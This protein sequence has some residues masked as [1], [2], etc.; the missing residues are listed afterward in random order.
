LS[1]AQYRTLSFLLGLTILGSVFFLPFTYRGTRPLTLY[2]VTRTIQEFLREIPPQYLVLNYVFLVVLVLLLFAGLT[3]VFPMVSGLTSVF[4][5]IVMSSAL[6]YVGSQMVLGSGY[7]V[8]LAS[9]MAIL[10]IGIWQI[11][12]HGSRSF[13]DTQDVDTIARD[14]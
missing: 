7:Y 10:C 14:L 1:L 8:V 3:G 9:S 12:A 11:R 4:A 2:E 13:S 5:M 6:F